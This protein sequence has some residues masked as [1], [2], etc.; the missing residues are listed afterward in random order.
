MHTSLNSFLHA[1]SMTTDQQA[2][3][4]AAGGDVN[5]AHI[6]PLQF[7]LHLLNAFFENSHIERSGAVNINHD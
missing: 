7:G 3:A 5:E 6:Q 1:V 2:Q 4:L